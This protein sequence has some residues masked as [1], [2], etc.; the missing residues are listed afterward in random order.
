MSLYNLARWSYEQL[1]LRQPETEFK[2]LWTDGDRYFAVC[3]G[4]DGSTKERGGKQ[5]VKWF[6]SECRVAGVPITLVPEV[7]SGTAPV[8]PRGLNEVIE[9]R[10]GLMTTRDLFVNLHFVLPAEFPNFALR[11][12]ARHGVATIEIQVA[13]N[14]SL[15]EHS[16]LSKAIAKIGVSRPFSVSLLP[17]L[18]PDELPFRSANPE[19]DIDL[20]PS[21]RVSSA[22]FRN[23]RWLVEEDDDFWATNRTKLLGERS[24]T[25]PTDAL[26]KGFMNE[27]LGCYVDATTFLAQNLRS[28][29]A[30]YNTVYLSPPIGE[31]PSEKLQALGATPQELVQLVRCG[32]L[33]LVLPQSVDRYNQDWLS[34]AA[35]ACPRGIL[36]SRR[37][38]AAT[39][40]D[41]RRRWPIFYPPFAFEERKACLLAISR[42]A[43]ALN[44][45]QKVML[46]GLIETL[47]TAWLRTEFFVNTRGAMATEVCGIGELVTSFYKKACNKDLTL[48]FWSAA[49]QVERAGALGANV[50]PYASSGFNSEPFVDLVAGCFSG[51]KN[52]SL[53]KL[54]TDTFALLDEILT[55]DNDVPLLTFAQEWASGDIERL[56][57]FIV[58]LANWK[59]EPESRQEAIDAFNAEVRRY[60]RRPDR[61]KA[62]NIVGLCLSAAV[63]FGVTANPELRQSPAMLFSSAGIAM[64]SIVFHLG[65]EEL[66][67][68]SKHL[69]AAL[70]W[71]NAL[72]AGVQP[73][74]VLVSR[75]R[76]EVKLIKG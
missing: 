21:R 19:G 3:P 58:D 18:I 65:R 50:A 49:S 71:T 61:L 16:E 36:L 12:V 75:L 35:E 74:A 52:A 70:D 66:T 25:E 13:Q 59:Q 73:E 5:L 64:A 53:A 44:G 57:K 27:G 11:N 39:I 4:V 38:A 63:A 48:E 22:R 37:L 55:I 60:E 17:G 51:G 45:E 15:E 28:Y 67:N 42:T 2:G 14:L 9:N 30:L 62:F 31:N 72:L 7:P 34:S 10:G 54:S 47:S 68:K 23:L 29:L 26:K 32:R 41:T 46:E 20:V 8:P 1:L 40:I 6:N 69:S 43:E 56:R 76:K 33:R 24:T